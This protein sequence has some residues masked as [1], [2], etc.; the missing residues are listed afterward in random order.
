VVPQ[1]PIVVAE[2]VYAQYDR[3]IRIAPAKEI[4][5]S[6]TTPQQLAAEGFRDLQASEK[7]AIVV[8]LNLAGYKATLTDTGA[9]VVAVDM[10]S[11]A[12]KVLKPGDEITSVNGEPVDKPSDVSR[13]LGATPQSANASISVLRDSQDVSFVVPLT[14]DQGGTSKIGI[15]LAPTGDQLD[16]P[17]EVSIMPRKVVGG[18]SAGL[19]FTLAVYNAVTPEDITHGH[20]IAGT[21]TIDLAGDIGAI[22]GVRQKVAAAERAGA[23]YFL[24]PSA[25][26]ADARAAASG[27]TVV[28]VSTA[29]EA[30]AFLRT[31]P[32]QG[33]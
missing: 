9:R 10:G 30:V 24:V 2:W 15:S 31:L 16:L 8:G 21:G 12:A 19:M 1:A 13:I 17:F 14:H 29:H 33:R 25:N 18:P 23:E 32:E 11:A 4:V 5:S 22:G 7:T 28:E 3:A 27:I 26:Y 20:K 6:N